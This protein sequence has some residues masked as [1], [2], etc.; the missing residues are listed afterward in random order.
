MFIDIWQ[1][2]SG[3]AIDLKVMIHT[4]DADIIHLYAHALNL[5]NKSL[6]LRPR[7]RTLG[8]GA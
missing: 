8:R 2:A 3:V 5:A 4:F 7:F 6:D 1:N